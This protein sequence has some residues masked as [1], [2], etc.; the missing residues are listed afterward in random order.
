MLKRSHEVEQIL[1]GER[2]RRQMSP[3]K[4]RAPDCRARSS[5]ADENGGMCLKMDGREM[6]G[7]KRFICSMVQ[8]YGSKLQ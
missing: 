3:E 7:R 2:R 5:E 8:G 4:M 1:A 6:K